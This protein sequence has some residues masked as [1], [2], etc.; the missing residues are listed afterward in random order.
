MAREEWER[1]VDAQRWEGMDPATLLTYEEAQNRAKDGVWAPVAPKAL[2][3]D[4]LPTVQRVIFDALVPHVWSLAVA[5]PAAGEFICSD[6]PLVWSRVEPWE[7]G[8]NH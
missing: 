5:R 6:S 8:F 4:R 1:I 2:V 7:P 3:L